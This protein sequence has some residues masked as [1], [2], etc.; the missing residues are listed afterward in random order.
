VND[1]DG[2]DESAQWYEFRAFVL[3]VLY[4]TW[5]AELKQVSSPEHRIATS[6]QA[7]DLVLDRA[8]RTVLVNIKLQTPQTAPRLLS[9]AEEI[10]IQGAEYK[11]FHP[12]EP[13]PSLIVTFPGVLSASR[14]SLLSGN[15]LEILDGAQLRA[16]AY[17]YDIDVPPF[18]ADISRGEAFPSHLYAS[19]LW[20]RS[21]HY[22]KDLHALEWPDS[23]LN[24]LSAIKPGNPHWHIYENYCEELLNFLFVPPLSPAIP[25]SRNLSNI[26]RRDF[27]L[28]NYAT[29]GF[30]RF[31]QGRYAADFVVAEVKNLRKRPGKSEILQVA[32]YLSPHGTGLFALMLSRH[33]M[34]ETATW[35]C[36]EQWAQNGKMIVSLNDDDVRQMITTKLTGGEP[37]DMVRQKIEDFRLLI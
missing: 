17:Q 22:A 15:R 12:G 29:D 5:E 25:Q 28:P 32:N 23:L 3:Q 8:G 13:E 18:V 37:T 27:I 30:W 4:R 34:D 36:R 24:R 7:A 9:V 2:P 11:R 1:S 19:T 33:L 31:M 14:T 35:I 10:V 6:D 16:K 20:D 26:N 21:V